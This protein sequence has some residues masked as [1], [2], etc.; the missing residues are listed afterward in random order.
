MTIMREKQI[1]PISDSFD[2]STL[3]F[4]RDRFELISV[5]QIRR[6]TDHRLVARSG[7]KRWKDVPCKEV[8]VTLR[9]KRCGTIKQVVDKQ[10]IGCKQGPCH[11]K[12]IDL[13][14]RRFGKLEVLEFVNKPDERHAAN[15]RWYWKCKCDCGNICYKSEHDLLITKHTQCGP[16]ARK[17]VGSLVK[18][19][20]QMAEWHREYRMLQRNAKL[21]GY[22]CELTLDQFISLCKEPCYYCGDAPEIRSS[23]LIKN[24]VDRFDNKIGYTKDNCVPCCP[25]CNTI[26]LDYPYDFIIGHIEK[27][28]RHCKERS[29]TISQESTPKQAETDSDQTEEITQPEETSFDAQPDLGF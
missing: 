12:W 8:V 27:M 18:L 17:Y 3:K 14:G 6:W 11:Q 9:C 24:G 23:G 7:G 29:T 1:E 5:D 25:T 2:V 20:D 13:A 22:S 4:P 19:P 16:C 15:I 10:T 28:L 26:K 21:R